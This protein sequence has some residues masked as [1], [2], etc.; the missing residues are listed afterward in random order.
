LKFPYALI[1]TIP[2]ELSRL[3]GSF[4]IPATHQWILDFIHPIEFRIF[5]RGWDL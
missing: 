5:R 1:S 3:F 4:K 2:K